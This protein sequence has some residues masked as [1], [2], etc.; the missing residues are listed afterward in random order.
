[1]QKVDLAAYDGKLHQYRAALD[2]GADHA[3]VAT[4]IAETQAERRNTEAELRTLTASAPARLN[5]AEISDLIAGEQRS[6][7]RSA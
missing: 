1:V 6:W 7:R 4:W 3:L 2:A 5:H